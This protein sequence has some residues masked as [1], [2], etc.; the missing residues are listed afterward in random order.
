MFFSVL[1]SVGQEK[2]AQLFS[3]TP[4]VL[5]GITG[6]SNTDFPDRSLQKQVFLSFGWQHTKHTDEWGAYLKNIKTGLS[7]GG[8]Y[9][10]GDVDAGYYKI[11]RTVSA[12]LGLKYYVIST[13]KKPETNFYIGGFINSNLGQADF[14]EVAIGYVKTF[15]LK[16]NK[17]NR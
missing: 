12:R 11:K 5:F 7:I 6:E 9:T 1:Y 13:A 15:T 8:N 10:L 4:E 17:L 16:D 2:N 14:S 3:I